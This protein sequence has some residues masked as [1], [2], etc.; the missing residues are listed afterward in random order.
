MTG[1]I[2]PNRGPSE[3]CKTLWSVVWLVGSYFNMALYIPVTAIVRSQKT[4]WAS[5][6][7]YA[8]RGYNDSGEWI[9][10]PKQ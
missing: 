2:R 9:C 5:V 6:F 4:E 10:R 3:L 1:L 7:C 8:R